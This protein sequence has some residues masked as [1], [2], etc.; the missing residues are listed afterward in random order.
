MEAFIFSNLIYRIINSKLE[1]LWWWENSFLYILVLVRTHNFKGWLFYDVCV[2]CAGW[3]CKLN[4][5]CILR[6]FQW[7][8]IP[9]HLNLAAVSKNVNHVLYFPWCL[10]S[11]CALGF[12]KNILCLC[13]DAYTLTEVT[14][15][16]TRD[17]TLS[18]EV[19]PDGSRLNQYDLTGQTVGKETIKSSTGKTFASN[20]K[21]LWIQMLL[22]IVLL[23]LVFLS[24]CVGEY[25]VM[26]A[27]FHLKRKI[28]Y[29]VIQTY[30]PC[31]MTVILSQVSF[32]LNRES[33]PARTVF[34]GWACVV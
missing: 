15:V 25:T 10:L 4:A 33:V 14:Y 6:T 19:A 29:F 8:S 18:V 11:V 16:W 5:R 24:C 1:L 32:W 31:I 22:S 7:T 17:A 9:A 21:I 23:S 30:L 20:H 28:G 2:S 34:G 13:V 27:H 26:T 3:Q 12:I